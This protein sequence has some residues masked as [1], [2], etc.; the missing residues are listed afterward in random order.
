V[1]LH[2]EE[3]KMIGINRLRSSVGADLKNVRAKGID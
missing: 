1:F 3:F 2:V